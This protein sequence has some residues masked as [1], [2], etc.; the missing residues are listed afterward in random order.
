MSILLILAAGG[1]LLAIVL[2]AVAL[3]T[4]KSDSKKDVSKNDK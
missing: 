4:N 1:A 3:G 2:I